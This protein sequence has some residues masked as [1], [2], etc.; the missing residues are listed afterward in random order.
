MT[1]SVDR[2]CERGQDADP[3]SAP[4]LTGGRLA[5]RLRQKCLWPPV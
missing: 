2:G 1:A 4:P 3:R 5:R